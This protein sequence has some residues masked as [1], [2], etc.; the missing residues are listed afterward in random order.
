MGTVQYI[1]EDLCARWDREYIVPPP[2]TAATMKL[3][4]QH[5]PET[6]CL[7]LKLTIGNLIQGLE[8]GADTTVMVGGGGPCRFGYYADL[9]RRILENLGYEFEAYTIEP[10]GQR[11]A[12]FVKTVKH[13]AGGRSYYQT[14]QDVKHCFRKGQALDRIEREGN[15]TR[16]YEV[17]RGDT[18][19]ARDE[20]FEIVRAA[21]TWNE[22]E[23][24]EREA[25]ALMAAVD[26]DMSRDVLKVG[27]VG[28][29]YLILEPFTNFDIEEYLGE[30]G[31]YVDRGTYTSDWIGVGDANPIFGTHEEEIVEAAAPYL[32]HWV[33]GDGQVAIGRTVL[34]KERGFDG[35][36][37]L[38]PF[39]CM[40]EIIAKQI[41]PVVSR[42]KDM[43]Y[44]SLVVDEQTGKAGVHTRLE[45]FLDLLESRRRQGRLTAPGGSPR[46]AAV[47]PDEFEEV[48]GVETHDG[49]DAGPE[50]GLDD[51]DTRTGGGPRERIEA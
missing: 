11:P 25:L 51:E 39:T 45:A 41:L 21:W 44:L 35:V 22:I 9:Q 19:K 15:A 46:A 24:A 5:G 4:V 14:F 10:P 37:H 2:N 47:A 3:G 27:L 6:A 38:L 49:T 50:A 13:L 8:A 29:F 42:E 7:P 17:T 40:P 43:P 33:G 16:C 32:D 34:F 12:H 1:I 30:R 26:E 36:V 48:V 18:N 28:E 23:E 31:V 20:G